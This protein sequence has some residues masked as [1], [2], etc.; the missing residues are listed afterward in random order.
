MTDLFV[1]VVSHAGSRYAVSQGPEG[2]GARLVAG[3]TA[4]GLSAACVVNTE[5]A[6]DPASLPIDDPV[7]RT[8]VKAQLDLEA[9]WADFLRAETPRTV[10]Q[11]LASQAWNAARR[12][13]ATARYVRPW[14]RGAYAST[15]GARMV[16][17]L[18][19]IEMSHVRLWEQGLSSGA[20]W[21]VIIEDD[22]HSEDVEDCTQG[23]AALLSQAEA[24]AKYVNLSLSFGTAELGIDHLMTS[25][26]GITW[27]GTL[28]RM[29]LSTSRPVTN[30][31]CAIAY[32]SDFVS[33]LLREFSLLPMTP[34]VPID[35]KLNL[36]LMNMFERGELDAGDCWLVEPGPIT[37]MSM[38]P[39]GGA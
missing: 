21:V 31:V 2:L 12:A 4:R 13:R 27:Q 26:P 17:R 39:D 29:V 5:D 32:R 28:P 16:R 3:L 35:W 22:A 19:N 24:T 34:V 33:A 1:G 38:Q 36:A 14:Q 25:M 15:P 7:V 23:L 9:A 10:T 11:R 18:V 30:T 37:Q 20:R 6:Y 8:S